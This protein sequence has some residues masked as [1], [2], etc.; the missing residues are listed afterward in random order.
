M[1]EMTQQIDLFWHQIL[2]LSILEASLFLTLFVLIWFLP[3]ILALFY[4]P[5]QRKMILIINV[6]AIASW[7]LWGALLIWATTGNIKGDKLK[8]LVHKFKTS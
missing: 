7:I 6:F 4:N 5:Q 3:T 2:T 8:K 1:K